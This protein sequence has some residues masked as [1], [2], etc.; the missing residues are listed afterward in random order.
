MGLQDNDNILFD[1]SPLMEDHRAESALP[2]I[3]TLEWARLS[4]MKQ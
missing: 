4:L 3:S 1:A 2:K